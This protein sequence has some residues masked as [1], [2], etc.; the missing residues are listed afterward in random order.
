MIANHP[1]IKPQSLMR[2]LVYAA[3]PLGEGVIADPFLGSGSTVAAA[4]AVGVRCI[5]I[6]RF[7]DYYKMARAGIPRL[8][9][10]EVK[11]PAVTEVEDL[12]KDVASPMRGVSRPAQLPFDFD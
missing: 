2:Q 5:G 6:E 9:A 12:K 3:L 11:T 10:L 1:S 8:A 4:E 7:A